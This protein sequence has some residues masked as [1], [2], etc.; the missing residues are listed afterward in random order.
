MLTEI[1]IIILT[2]GNDSMKSPR[3]QVVVSVSC[4]AKRV[5]DMQLYKFVTCMTDKIIFHYLFEV[6]TMYIKKFCVES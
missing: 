5:C 3:W 1:I 6:S 2:V 4:V